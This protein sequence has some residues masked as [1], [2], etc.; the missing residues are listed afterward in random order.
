MA[1]ARASHSRAS[2]RR[3]RSNRPEANLGIG[4][5]VVPLRVIQLRS[6]LDGALEQARRRKHGFSAEGPRFHPIAPALPIARSTGLRRCS[7][8]ERPQTGD[9]NREIT[10]EATQADPYLIAHRVKTT[11]RHYHEPTAVRSQRERLAPWKCLN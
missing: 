11:D 6:K 9:R 8:R 2:A 4:E 5:G 10:S 3:P 7:T 1:F